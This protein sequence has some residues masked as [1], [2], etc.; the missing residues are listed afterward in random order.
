MDADRIEEL[1]P[2]LAAAVDR[3]NAIVQKFEEHPEP[4]VKDLVFEL[5]SNVD[6]VHRLGLRRLN[7]LL[8]VAGLQRRATDDPEVRLLFDLYD[9]GEGGDEAR[10]EAMVESLKAPL[11]A[12]GAQMELLRADAESIQVRFIPPLD[13]HPDAIEELRS[14]LEQM[15]L[16]NLPGVVRAEVE[17]PVV[18]A[19]LRNN[20][21]PLTALRV[22]P[23]L[24]W[25]TAM[26]LTDLPSG[27][28]VGVQIADERVLLAN[29]GGGEVYAYRNT[30]PE[31]PFPL[32]AGHV[33]TGILHCPWHGCQ[34][35]LRGGR[36]VDIEAPGLGVIPVRVEDGVIRVSI[37]R[38]AVAT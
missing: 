29:L 16:D 38:S 6:T 12:M 9:L 32:D 36:R 1:P 30:C 18:P 3:V 23:K 10:A 19:S 25:Q 7:E 37:P 28:L 27:G 4:A 33:E 24:H 13:A 21:V 11:A 35:D 31:T 8:K 2:E 17:V 22:P 20:F 34:F 15:L 14:A 5:L 26:P